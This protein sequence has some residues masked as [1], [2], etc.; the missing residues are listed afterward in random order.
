M[1]IY[2]AIANLLFIQF[3]GNILWCDVCS[4]HYVPGISL[5]HLQVL[6]V[7]S[8]EPSGRLSRVSE[9]NEGLHGSKFGERNQLRWFPQMLGK[10]MQLLMKQFQS[11][12]QL[13]EYGCGLDGQHVLQ[14]ADL[15]HVPDQQHV[16]DHSMQGWIAVAVGQRLKLVK[17][18]LFNVWHFGG[19]SSG[20]L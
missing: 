6:R 11:Y 13:M 5:W 7:K 19:F 18:C 2:G 3:K 14:H 8:N 9:Q 20:S 12:F 1:L 10:I 15:V 16:M 17:V 4:Q